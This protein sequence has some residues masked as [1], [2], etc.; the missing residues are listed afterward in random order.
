M[1]HKNASVLQDDCPARAR[2]AAPLLVATGVR[3][4]AERVRVALLVDDGPSPPPFAHTSDAYLAE[5]R[6]PFVQDARAALIAQGDASV[7]G[8][9][10]WRCGLG[11][12]PAP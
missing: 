9:L 5:L 10:W 2:A 3:T 11:H 8:L 6:G 7:G 1:G 4:P 12:S